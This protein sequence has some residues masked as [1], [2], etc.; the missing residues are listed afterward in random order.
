MLRQNS[1]IRSKS[2]GFTLVESMVVVALLSILT[3]LA[4]PS[5]REAFDSY[6][7]N[8]AFDELRSSYALARSEAI[9]NRSPVLIQANACASASSWECGWTIFAVINGVNQTVKTIEA[10]TGGTTITTFKG[11]APFNSVTFDRW[12][13]RTPVETMRQVIAPGGDSTAAGTRTLCSS[14]GGR[15]RSLT[16]VQGDVACNAQ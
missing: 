11:T 5:M 13:N 15:I 14:A 12:G 3:A 7:S 4:A 9:R 16:G 10:R 1:L 8:E 2:P 6:R